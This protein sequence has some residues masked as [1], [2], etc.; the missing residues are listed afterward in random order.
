[1]KTAK[2]FAILVTA[3][4]VL[5]LVGVVSAAPPADNPGKGP[6]ELDKIVF[7]HYGKDCALGKP[8]DTPGKGPGGGEEDEEVCPY[9]YSRI[10]WP[11]GPGEFVT[12]LIN[13]DKDGNKAIDEAELS[14]RDGMVAAFQTWTS[15]NGSY[16]V[17]VDGGDTELSPDVINPAAP[18]Y[19]NVVGWEYLTGEY[20]EGVIGVTVVWYIVGRRHIV[21][22][23]IALNTDSIFAWTQANIDTA[24]PNENWL[25]NTTYYDVDVQNIMTHE[26]GHWLMLEDLYDKVAIEQTMYYMAD[27][28]ELKKRSLESGDIAGIQKI[29]P[30]EKTHPGKGG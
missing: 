6:P 5:S 8:V 21:D 27:D 18:D 29:Y 9:S 19:K 17:F 28:C 11:I 30:V 14:F 24:D 15:V 13:P 22:A 3:A 2:L 16:M 4:L 1:M 26:A 10:H 7:I 12:Y 23:D 25:D 20:G